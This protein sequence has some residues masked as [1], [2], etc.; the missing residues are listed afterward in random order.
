MALISKPVSKER[1]LVSGARQTTAAAARPNGHTRRR[2]SLLMP[3]R[4]STIV[5]DVP[6]AVPSRSGSPERKEIASPQEQQ[7]AEEKAGFKKVVR[8]VKAPPPEFDMS[9]FGF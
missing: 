2:S 6:S 4:R 3:K 5:L 7:A 9:S 8:E 1:M